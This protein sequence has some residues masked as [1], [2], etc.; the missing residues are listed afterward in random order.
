MTVVSRKGK[1]IK[2]NVHISRENTNEGLKSEFPCRK[3]FLVKGNIQFSAVIIRKRLVKYYVW[4]VLL[5]ECET[6]TTGRRERIR[7]KS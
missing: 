4:S 5:Y 1:Y 6:R 3:M 7:R 2:L